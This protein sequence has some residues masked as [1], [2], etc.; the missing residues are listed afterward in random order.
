MSIIITMGGLPGLPGQIDAWDL[1]TLRS[2]DYIKA[3]ALPS[4]YREE[5]A[6]YV[7]TRMSEGRT[8]VDICDYQ[9][10]DAPL[11]LP[12]SG[13][14]RMWF[15]QDGLTVNGRSLKAEYLN[16]RESMAD[17]VFEGL[18]SI[19]AQPLKGE[20]TELR[21]EGEVLENVLID[22]ARVGKV[23]LV[24]H[25]DG[26][27]GAVTVTADMVGMT[28]Q[29]QACPPTVVNKIQTLDNTERTKI[30]VDVGKFIA[31]RV[32]P[33]KYGDRMAHQMLDENG[34]PA[35]AGITVIVDGAPGTV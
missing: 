29:V 32:S 34:N 28:I 17:A 9:T 6:A 3:M 25:G 23:L 16:A 24:K 12:R 10:P 27:V 11:G 18:Q 21:T 19:A 8:L 20:R 15:Q 2:V 30:Q 1:T 33:A 7:L 26:S 22:V 13:V 14:V 31:S 5:Y 35:K 4:Q